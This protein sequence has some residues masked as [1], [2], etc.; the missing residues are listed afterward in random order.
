MNSMCVR[1]HACMCACACVHVCVL[2]QHKRLTEVSLSLPL[3]REI[4]GFGAGVSHGLCPPA[5]EIR[6]EKA[7][8]HANMYVVWISHIIPSYWVYIRICT[9]IHTLDNWCELAKHAY[10]WSRICI[11]NTTVMY[12]TVLWYLS[13]SYAYTVYYILWDS[14]T[15]TYVHC[16][17][18]YVCHF[19]LLWVNHSVLD[20]ILW[21]CY[22]R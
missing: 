3:Q 11:W 20:D 6:T 4:Q 10:E 15:H 12:G 22:L 9:Y 16:M 7:C 19:A 2:T 1:V 14:Y 8:T 5:Q 18:M 21:E 13:D 17:Y